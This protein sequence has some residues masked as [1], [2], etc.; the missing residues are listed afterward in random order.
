M[1]LI[2]TIEK[3]GDKLVLPFEIEKFKNAISTNSDG[4]G[5]M[6]PILNKDTGKVE[7][8]VNKLKGTQAEQYE[9]LREHLLGQDWLGSF[10]MHMRYKTRGENDMTNVH[11]FPVLQMEKGE[12]KDLYLM[13]NGTLDSE[14]GDAQR[15]DS[16]HFAEEVL[17]PML[18]EKP[19]M[20]NNPGFIKLTE[21]AI[22]SGN[23]FLLMDEKG[24]FVALNR[25]A[26]TEKESQEGTSVLLSNTYSLDDSYSGRWGYGHWDADD[27]WYKSTKPHRATDTKT[28]TAVTTVTKKDNAP[29]KLEGKVHTT[30]DDQ[31]IEF[32]MDGI[33]TM[34]DMELVKYVNEN[35][36]ETA[37]YLRSLHM[38]FKFN[39][40][41][42]EA[43]KKEEKKSD[44][45]NSYIATGNTLTPVDTKQSACP[46]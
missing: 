10:A 14:W 5:I 45:S 33:E 7:F 19:S 36:E 22:G 39:F 25:K 18:L 37:T 38:K 3:K 21:A 46:C 20:W 15:S 13:H 12:A 6:Y 2:T 43:D 27:N 29:V 41:T 40:Q 11:P 44:S 31:Q 23:K 28:T 9:F 32:L 16:R 30:M 42:S 17:R 1:C 34:S 4:I 24:K 35:P 26:W 8:K